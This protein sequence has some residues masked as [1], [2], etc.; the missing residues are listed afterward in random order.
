MDRLDSDGWGGRAMSRSRVAEV[1]A[2]E[3]PDGSYVNLGIGMPTLVGDALPEGKEIILHSEN[4]ILGMGPPPRPGR[5][6]WNLIN[7]G[8]EPVTLLRGGCYLNHVEAFAMIRGGHLDIAVLG[9]FEVSS[10][11]DLANWSSTEMVPA[12]GG[13]MDL[14]VGARNVY[15]IMTYLTRNG[16]PKLVE[17]CTYPITARGVV[18][19]IYTDVAVVD[20]TPKGFELS[21]VVEDVSVG[22][23]AERAGAKLGVA[24]QLTIL[25][26]TSQGTVKTTK[27]V[28]S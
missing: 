23:L 18:R 5:E 1:L 25:H 7:A 24:S 20:V 27:Q 11:G 3:I 8:K 17:A 12:V 22:E 10:T 15:V 4:G 28:L 2:H 21:A 26:R 14:A 13:A 19:R 6:D 9:G 16:R